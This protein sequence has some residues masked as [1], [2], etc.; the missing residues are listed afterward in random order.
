MSK[1]FGKASLF[2]AVMQLYPTVALVF[3]AGFRPT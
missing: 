1:K 3:C 2:F